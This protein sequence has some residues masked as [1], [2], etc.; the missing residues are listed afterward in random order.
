MIAETDEASL[1]RAGVTEPFGYIVKPFTERELRVNIELALCK[2]DAARAV[3]ELEDRFFAGSIDM[4]R[5]LDFN[6]CSPGESRRTPRR[7]L[8][9]LPPSRQCG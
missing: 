6:W 1:R 2:H 3:H 4:L 9:S 8:A 7:G 5:F